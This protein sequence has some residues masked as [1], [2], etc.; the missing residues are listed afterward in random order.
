MRIPIHR[1]F[2]ARKLYAESVHYP[3]YTHLKDEME[4][5]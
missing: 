4:S 3:A 2:H 1:E 5:F